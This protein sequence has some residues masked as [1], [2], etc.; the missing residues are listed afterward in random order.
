MRRALQAGAN[1]NAIDDDGDSALRCV[2]RCYGDTGI[3]MFQILL[4]HG[5]DINW[6]DEDGWAIL[7][8]AATNGNIPFMQFLLDHGADANLVDN[9]GKTAYDWAKDIYCYEAMRLLD[10]WTP[11]SQSAVSNPGAD[12]QLFEAIQ[13]VALAG[14]DIQQVRRALQAGANPNAVNG[15]GDSAFI[16]TTARASFARIKDNGSLLSS[17]FTSRPA[18]STRII[19][20]LQM[21]LDHGARVNQ[22]AAGRCTALM[23]AAYSG[24]APVVQFLLDQGSDLSLADRGG[25]RALDWSIRAL[26]DGVEADTTIIP[27]LQNW[28]PVPVPAYT[29]G[30]P[31]P[32]YTPP[33]PTPAPEYTPGAPAPEYTPGA[34]A[35]DYSPENR[36]S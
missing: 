16:Y 3:P 31:L 4:D 10:S 35:P 26:M 11:F 30:E 36:P 34:P 13:N 29:P 33:A 2:S 12:R 5:A 23:C 28:V 17:S 24:T 18:P 8:H 25:R 32:T 15:E 9:R 21:L 14:G 1:P 19:P 7:F 22:Q 20:I 6:Q 27:T